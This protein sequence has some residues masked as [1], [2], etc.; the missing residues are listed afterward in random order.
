MA[1]IRT[2][3]AAMYAHSAKLQGIVGQLE[4]V[5]GAFKASAGT[6]ED[7]ITA[8]QASVA[9]LLG[10]AWQSSSASGAYDAL[11]ANWNSHS[12]QLKTALDELFAG[13]LTNV[14]NDLEQISGRVNTASANYEE[15]EQAVRSAIGS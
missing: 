7:H 5:I 15:G 11:Q 4:G 8:V 1:T 3:T 10:E 9:Q 12:Q 13:P 14:M 6:L 2:D